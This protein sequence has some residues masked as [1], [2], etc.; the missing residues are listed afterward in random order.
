MIDYSPLIHPRSFFEIDHINDRT[1]TL[2]FPQ[3][4]K[5]ETFLWDVEIFG[6]LQRVFG[7]LVILKGGAAAQLLV[8]PDKQRTSVDIDVIFLGKPEDL[9]NSL[10]IIHRDF[11]AD[12]SYFKFI[13][14]DP[15]APKAIIP[16]VTYHIP[17]PSVTKNA[18]IFIKVD[19]HFMDTLKL[20]SAHLSDG[21]A[22]G[23]PL[24][25]TPHC[26]TR[27]SLL[28]DKLLTLAQ[29]SVGI[30]TDRET[31]IP[32]QLYDLDGLTR[33]A[34]TEDAIAMIRAMEILIEH[35]ITDK[36]EQINF[37][38][39]LQE[40][41][42]LLDKYSR[43][44]TPK[45]DLNARKALD[46]FKSN[47]EPRPYRNHI[48]WGIISKRLS[49]LV[50]AIEIDPERA[51]EILKKADRIEHAVSNIQDPNIGEIRK[52]IA[53]ELL[54]SLK[55]IGQTETAKRLKNT[56]PER[57]LWEILHPSNLDVIESLIS[58]ISSRV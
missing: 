28:G 54:N 46:N 4:V 11:G 35:E 39:V 21:N 1:T 15:K 20:E 5:V 48:S 32:K 56:M 49:F 27:A 33:L 57:I 37:G 52:S 29:G 10:D 34:K 3:A 12:E 16:M 47:Y 19:F 43:M 18:P 53:T 58:K 44:D 9:L 14:L 6:Q 13:L 51:I 8:P 31:E 26:L 50:T 36:V 25:F 55:D 24:S 2:N 45:G 7:E 17:V 40:M 22:F 42:Q 41:K 30:S 38:Q 23:T